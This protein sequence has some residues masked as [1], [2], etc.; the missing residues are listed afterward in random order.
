MQNTF[1]GMI[2]AITLLGVLLLSSSGCATLFSGS[3]ESVSINSDPSGATILI[4]GIE[5]GRTPAT[6][7]VRRAG[8]GS[9][10]VTLRMPG[11]QDRSFVLQSTFN[12][13][14]LVNVFFWP[15]FIVDALTGS[16]TKY[17]P[18]TYTTTMDRERNAMAEK[19]GV[20]HIVYVGELASDITGNLIVPAGAEGLSIAVVDPLLRQAVL[21]R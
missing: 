11:Y 1:G 10:T 13:V 18:K 19:L 6:L 7:H 16:I 14:S 3:K 8:L 17:D 9:K 5:M 2:R 15:G 12:A 20:D 21:L 4:D